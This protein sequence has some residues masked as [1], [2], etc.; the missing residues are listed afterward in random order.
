[1]LL[2][3]IDIILMDYRES[4]NSYKFLFYSEISFIFCCGAPMLTILGFI[5]NNEDFI[6]NNRNLSYLNWKSKS[7][8]FS[9]QMLCELYE[10]VNFEASLKNSEAQLKLVKLNRIKVKIS[11]SPDIYL[12]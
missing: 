6:F 1:M 2:V 4:S 10:L 8:Y 11:P 5:L 12:L 7:L 3:Y 9:Q